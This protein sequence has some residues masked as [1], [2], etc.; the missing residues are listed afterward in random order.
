MKTILLSLTCVGLLLSGCGDHRQPDIEFGLQ[1]LIWTNTLD[2]HGLSIAGTGLILSQRRSLPGNKL[3]THGGTHFRNVPLKDIGI[4]YFSCEHEH[5]STKVKT[6]FRNVSVSSNPTFVAHG[7]TGN[8]EFLSGRNGGRRFY[9]IKGIGFEQ[10]K[11]YGARATVNVVTGTGDS[12]GFELRFEQFRFDGSEGKVSGSCK[13]ER[14]LTPK[15]LTLAIQAMLKASD[16]AIAS[17]HAM[18]A[19][20]LSR[21]VLGYRESNFTAHQ[22]PLVLRNETLL[23]TEPFKLVAK[24][25][26]GL[27]K[28]G[29]RAALCDNLTLFYRGEASTTDVK[30]DPT[31]TYRLASTDYVESK[32]GNYGYVDSRNEGLG[33][34]ITQ[35]SAKDFDKRPNFALGIDASVFKGLPVADHQKPIDRLAKFEEVKARVAKTLAACS[36]MTKE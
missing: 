8:S 19:D 32:F 28:S 3:Q 4:T 12:A 36:A 35:K 5:Y 24:T 30:T 20:D 26:P 21:L 14:E 29:E 17:L 7:L 6:K 34:S 10:D 11:Y 33:L 9:T 27:R 25:F 18:E 2:G 15:E 1:D 22:E 31:Q 23:P 13:P 16:T